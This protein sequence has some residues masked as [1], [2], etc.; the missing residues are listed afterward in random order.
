VLFPVPV[1]AEM[2][3]PT[4]VSSTVSVPHLVDG[5]GKLVPT[6]VGGTRDRQEFYF[7]SLYFRFLPWCNPRSFRVNLCAYND[8]R[9]TGTRLR[10]QNHT[11]GFRLT[12]WQTTSGRCLFVSGRSKM[13]PGADMEVGT[14]VGAGKPVGST[15]RARI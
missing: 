13:A 12:I 3:N 14:L 2:D 11:S 15:R 6:A 10:S 4:R 5:L 1:G 7:R 9:T 8:L